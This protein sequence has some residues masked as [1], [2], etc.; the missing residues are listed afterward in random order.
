MILF[1]DCIARYFKQSR[2]LE[3]I[4]NGFAIPRNITKVTSRDVSRTYQTSKMELWIGYVHN[5]SEAWE[6]FFGLNVSF[7]RNW[8]R[9][10]AGNY[11]FQVNNR[12]NITGCEICSKLIIK[13][14]GITAL[15]LTSKIFQGL[16]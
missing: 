13:I 12:N 11:M 14:P 9:N 5:I 8:E 16:F 7:Y 15:L 4:V 6:N 1:Y 10:P 3:T 2:L